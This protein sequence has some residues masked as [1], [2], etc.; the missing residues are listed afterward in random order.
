MANKS[1]DFI[2]RLLIF[3]FAFL[4]IF[5]KVKVLNKSYIDF[6]KR[7]K[8]IFKNSKAPDSIIE[9]VVSKSDYI[10]RILFTIYFLFAFLAILDY[11]FAKV[12]TGMIT[13]FMALIYCN[14]T[15]TIKKNLEKDRGNMNNWKNFIPSLEFCLISVVGIIM[16][17]CSFKPRDDNNEGENNNTYRNKK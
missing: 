16:I 3:Q 8:F 17:L 4:F 13:N 14:P 5:S 1:A 9:L 11:D 2:K 12:Y 7:F 15:I 10:F 6:H